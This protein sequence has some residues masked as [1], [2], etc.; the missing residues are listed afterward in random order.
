[1]PIKASDEGISRQASKEMERM[2]D[3]QVWETRR[4]GGKLIYKEEVYM[5]QMSSARANKRKI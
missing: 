5:T 1:M 4:V 2:L 3:V